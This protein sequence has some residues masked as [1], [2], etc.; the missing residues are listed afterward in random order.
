[1]KEAEEA[2][3]W[4]IMRKEKLPIRPSCVFRMNLIK[5]GKSECVSSALVHTV[6]IILCRSCVRT[7]VYSQHSEIG[8]LLTEI[9]WQAG[10]TCSGQSSETQRT[11]DRKREG[12]CV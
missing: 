12:E 4:Y 6:C 11:S 8:Q 5:R 10:E 7:C 9:R 1:M 3:L 2:V